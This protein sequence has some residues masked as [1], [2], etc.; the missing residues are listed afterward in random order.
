MSNPNLNTKI[1]SQCPIEKPIYEFHKH[2]REMI[3]TLTPATVP[4]LID[5][6][7]RV[8][9]FLSLDEAKLLFRLASEVLPRRAIVEIGSYQGRSAV[10]LGLGAKLAGARVWAI[11]PHEDI[12]INET[13]HYGMENHA[14]LL[15]N[16]VEFEV[17]GVVRVVALDSMEVLD[18][19]TRLIDLLWI[20]GCHEYESVH[21]DLLWSDYMDKTGTIALHDSSGHY[22]DVTRALNEFLEAGQWI[23]QER[24]DATT[25][26]KRA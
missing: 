11:D 14:A 26:L 17:A 8:H 21:A 24:I 20:D 19:W 1:C 2:K 22:P 6:L 13:V 5:V 9:G 18:G 15:K 16:L 4:D 10:C 3:D 12:Q 7:N 23:I 25:V